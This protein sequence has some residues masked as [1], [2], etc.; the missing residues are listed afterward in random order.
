M[1]IGKAN[2]RTLFVALLCILGVILYSNTKTE[3]D[4]NKTAFDE[5]YKI[6]SIKLPSEVYFAGEKIS[7]EDADL[8]ERYDKEILTNIYWQSQTLLFI[9]RAHKFFPVIE[10]ILKEQSIPDDFKYLVV[11]ESGLQYH[12]VSPSNAA[13]YWQFI[14]ATA[15]RYG[16]AVNE[17][18]D[19][20]YHLEKSTLAA[21]AY[22]KEAFAEFNN[23]ALVAAS[24]NMGI[25]GLRK[26]LALQKVMTYKD[27][28]LNSETSRYLFRIIAIKNILEHPDHFGFYV[29]H[30]QKY[31]PQS[32]YRVRINNNISD[33]AMYALD[34]NLN[35]KILKLN[36]PWLRKN[37]Y[38]Y[39][40]SPVY[41]AFPKTQLTGIDYA[42]KVMNDTINL[43]E[44]HFTAGTK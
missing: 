42:G 24:Y 8:Y 28:Y 12:V 26:Q 27:L 9:K 37:N 23:W 4:K 44:T 11:A 18:V 34:N 33:L 14:E 29:P 19:E 25:D 15:K 20:R 7:L 32:V 21:C 36:N 39:T 17:E 1:I 22:F 40:G 35:Y 13:G 3:D 2:S 30:E 16:L 10:R 38:T 31:K 41:L 6:H 43:E 5:H